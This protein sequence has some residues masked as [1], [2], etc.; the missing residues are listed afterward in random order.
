MNL[1]PHICYQALKSRDRR[2]D[3]RFYVAV[4]S[5]K[6]YCR[7]VCPA[8]LPKSENC[9]FYQTAAA[10]EQAGYRPCLRCRPELAP[11][12]ANIDMSDNLL[13]NSCRLLNQGY[14]D[15]H[16]VEQ[17]AARIGIT[18][19]HLRRLFKERLDVSPQQ[20]AQTRRLLIAKQLLTD[21]QLPMADVA[22]QSGFN[23]QRSFN[24]QFKRHY[25][26][27]PSHLRKKGGKSKEYIELTLSYRPPY[28]WP[29]VLGFL[30]KRCIPGVEQIDSHSYKRT[31][32]IMQGGQLHRGWL[33]LTPDEAKYR[34]RL[35]ISNSLA[36]VLSQVLQKIRL[37]FDLDCNP[38]LVA[39][40]LTEFCQQKPGLRLPG[41]FDGFEMSIRAILGQQVTVKAA[42]T[43][44]TRLAKAFGSPLET[45]FNELNHC[46]PTAD[47]IA[48]APVAQLGELGIVRQRGRAIIT[49]AQA[50]SQGEIELSATADIESTLSALQN[51][52]GIGPWTAQYIA[53][54]ALSWPDAFPATDLGVIKALGTKNQREILARAEA[55]RPW[56][57]YAVM[58]LWHSDTE[59]TKDTP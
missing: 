52:S 32:R 31:V 26:L 46:F 16:S 19:R 57:A 13:N 23:S 29:L 22:L 35:Q 49:L 43:L 48:T 4:S 30:S 18:D 20:Y 11:G 14:L 8:Q 15:N 38:Q 56:R 9:S 1:E 2:F 41:A 3:G 59:Q 53:M 51:V 17:L 40:T 7:P 10:A 42:H 44:A 37:L 55:W 5:T 25:Q 58:H 54:R 28:D 6:I 34:V 50:V 39:Q 45:P 12:L 33:S 47:Q 21:T 24:T 27:T 36:P